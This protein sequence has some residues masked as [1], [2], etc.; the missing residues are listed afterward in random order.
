MSHHK[1]IS[2]NL[3]CWLVFQVSPVTMKTASAERI[4]KQQ[5]SVEEEVKKREGLERYIKSSRSAIRVY[6]S[7]SRYT[8]FSVCYKTSRY[9]N[10]KKVLQAQLAKNEMSIIEVPPESTSLNGLHTRLQEM[11]VQPPSHTS[12]HINLRRL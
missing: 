1:I 9:D 7:R 2:M 4:A 3:N 6:L 11:Q 8:T 10:C 12:L 5:V